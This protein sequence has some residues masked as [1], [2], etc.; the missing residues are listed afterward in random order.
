MT[1]SG[2]LTAACSNLTH[3]A[4]ASICDVVSQCCVAAYGNAI[5]ALVLTGSMA[6]GE[7][8]FIPHGTGWQVLGDAEFLVIFAQHVSPPT[9]LFLHRD[10]NR[11]LDSAGINC[12]ITINNAAV[13]YLQ[14]LKPHIFGY[15][16]R[17]KGKVLWG[18][19]QVLSMIPG[20][21]AAQIPWADAW[22]ILCNRIIEYLEAS[23]ISQNGK[24][25]LQ[26][27]EYRTVKLVLDA[28]TSFLVFAGN[29]V[30]S[31]QE[32]SEK[33][34]SLASSGLPINAPFALEPFAQL[35][36]ACTFLKLKPADTFAQLSRATNT[37]AI[38]HARRLWLWELA[39][40]TNSS[41]GTSREEL[42]TA[43]AR[44]Q[45]LQQR[46]VAW[47][48]LLRRRPVGEW[49]YLPRWLRQCL[50]GSPRLLIYTAAAK[51]FFA[52]P[53]DDF[54]TTEHLH[55]FRRL[56][57]LGAVCTIADTWEGAAQEVSR[58]YRELLVT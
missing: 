56:L 18:D 7:A 13:S 53:G 10:I 20:F 38:E 19:Q 15:E 16:L 22:E 25:R 47:L 57:P 6:R 27:V 37:S 11:L 2:P 29:Y 9:L 44:L 12:D 21:P 5:R 30:P 43:F 35:V 41:Q 24:D 14:N 8:T 34:S 54:V 31:Y 33:L 4:V 1:C 58:N 52:D 48:R 3:P 23:S 50:I 51:L 46:A 28:A 55:L 26:L 42:L 40:L 39:L 49:K 36:A 17:A 45:P 32:R